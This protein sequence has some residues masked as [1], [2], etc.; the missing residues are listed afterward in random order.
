[1]QQ[2]PTGH[3]PG[4]NHTSKKTHV[5]QCPLQHYLKQPGHGSNLMSIKRTMYKAVVEHIHNG[6]LLNHEKEQ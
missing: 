6:I 4:E 5:P 2:S 1:M 3:I